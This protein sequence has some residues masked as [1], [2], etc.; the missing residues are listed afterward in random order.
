M[1]P[2]VS[3]PFFLILRD[4]CDGNGDNQDDHHHYTELPKLTSTQKI[5]QG[6]LCQGKETYPGYQNEC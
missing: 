2:H 3:G 6:Y 5:Q 4:A 1:I